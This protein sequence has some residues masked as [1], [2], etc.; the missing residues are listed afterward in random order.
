MTRTYTLMIEGDDTG[1]SAYVPEL[2]VIL[3]TVERW[4]N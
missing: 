4:M 1:Y 2:P 3:V